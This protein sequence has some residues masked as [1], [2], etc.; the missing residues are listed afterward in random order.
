ML[1]GRVVAVALAVAGPLAF[2]GHAGAAVCAPW[3][4]VSLSDV[5]GAGT[6]FGVAAHSANDAMAVGSGGQHAYALHR[7]PGG[8]WQAVDV[9]ERGAE[10]VLRDVTRIP[11]TDDYWAVGSMTTD[12]GDVRT[13]IMRWTGRKWVAVPSPSV[14]GYRSTLNGVTALSATNA[15]AVGSYMFTPSSVR[16]SYTLALRWNGT[17]WRI[18]DTPSPIPPYADPPPFDELNDVL[19][20]SPGNLWSVGVMSYEIADEDDWSLALRR[21]GSTWQSFVM[22]Q[23]GYEDRLESL[24]ALSLRDIWTVGWSRDPAGEVDPLAYHWNGLAW[25]QVPLPPRTPSEEIVALYAVESLSSSKTWAV[26][27]QDVSLGTRAM[28]L[29]WNGTAWKRVDNPSAPHNSFL[30]GVTRVP[31]TEITWAV[32]GILYTAGPLIQR[33]C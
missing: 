32:G 10:S 23:Q 8:P 1:R 31:G 11:G 17:R 13:N 27:T 26:G 19:A 12:S 30:R 25:S 4:T 20:V 15:W 14:S 29:R 3:R 21:T 18:V 33:H 28:V 9:P 24:A 2:S 22:P 16:S 7:G 6:L 5:A